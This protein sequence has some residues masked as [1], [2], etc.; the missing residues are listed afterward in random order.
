MIRSLVFVA[1]VLAA[2]A[3]AMCCN[4]VAIVAPQVYSQAIVAQP[5][6]QP[7]VA[8]VVAPVSYA[9]A[10]PIVQQQVVVKQRV[11][12]RRQPLRRAAQIV[13]PPYGNRQALRAGCY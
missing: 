5:V 13:L 7:V 4:P 8:Q 9:V 3:V 2:P 6:Y 12:Q 10:A 1:T 11:V